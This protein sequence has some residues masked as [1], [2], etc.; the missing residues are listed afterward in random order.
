MMA[1]ET[2]AKDG[3]ES[4]IYESFEDIDEIA[5]IIRTAARMSVLAARGAKEEKR[6]DKMF[7]AQLQIWMNVKL[8]LIHI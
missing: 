3:E 6:H 2:M 5:K 7:K 1:H 8:S 4:K